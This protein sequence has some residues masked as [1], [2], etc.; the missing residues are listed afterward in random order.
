MDLEAPADAWYVYVAVAIVS[1]AL[2]GLAL[3]VSMGPPPDADAAANAIEGVTGS[4][5]P[6]SASYEHDA[7]TVT[8]DRKTITM[9]NEHGTSHASVSYGTVVP[10]NGYE[11]LE[12][13]TYGAS[14]DEVF[15][16]EQA[17]PHTDAS[18]EFFELVDSAD[19]ENSGS[20]LSADGELRART[21][22]IDEDS[23]MT[24]SVR[25]GRD[26]EVADAIESE[27]DTDGD[28]P[29]HVTLKL[30]GDGTRGTHVDIESTP[31]EETVDEPPSG[32]LETVLRALEDAHDW[33]KSS[34]CG[35]G[36]PFCDE[37]DDPEP[38]IVTSHSEYVSPEPGDGPTIR[39]FDLLDELDEPEDAD[40]FDEVWLGTYDLEVELR[41]PTLDCEARITES[42]KGEWVTLCGPDL[43]LEDFDDPHWHDQRGGVHYVTLVTV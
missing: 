18:A 36:N 37:G 40:E 39:R 7:E 26:G 1:V 14:V 2:G 19:E 43:T 5:H 31:I 32:I 25:T 22:A 13:L 35:D 6:G 12:E 16:A 33:V 27:F 4:E 41:N 29:N 30:E 17:D 20:E 21:I 15:A 10:V 23:T 34:F 9:E 24:A 8:I 3:G 28:I 42:Q 11:R 38:D